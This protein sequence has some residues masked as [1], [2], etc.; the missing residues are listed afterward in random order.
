MNRGHPCLP[1]VLAHCMGACVCSLDGHP[2]DE[3][4]R[5]SVCGDGRFGEKRLLLPLVQVTPVVS[6]EQRQRA[7]AARE[8]LAE[9]GRTRWAEYHAKA[10]AWDGS[11]SEGFAAYRRT[12]ADGM[13]GCACRD[14]W[15][16]RC[17]AVP[18]SATNAAEAFAL[19]VEDHDAVNVE[20]G[21]PQL[22]LAAAR[23][24]WSAP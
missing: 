8:A 17:D 1:C 4:V 9:A 10:L 6:D 19:S 12:L 14:H 20:T 21:K 5:Q 18:F 16:K 11:D 3:H 15:H 13:P 23:L 7:L 24:R 22:G 2:V